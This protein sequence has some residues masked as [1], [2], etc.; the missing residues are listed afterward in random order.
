MNICTTLDKEEFSGKRATSIV[1]VYLSD[2]LS[3][4]QQKNWIH[5][6]VYCRRVQHKI[7]FFLLSKLVFPIWS[8]YITFSGY[9]G[10]ALTFTYLKPYTLYHLPPYTPSRYPIPHD[11]TT[12]TFSLL[13]FY[14]RNR[15]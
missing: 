10:S 5:N 8:S 14:L 15:C 3:A 2:R 9:K 11:C 12:T 6:K 1:H 13:M 7:S 4:F